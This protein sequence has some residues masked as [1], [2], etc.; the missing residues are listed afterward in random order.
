MLYSAGF[1]DHV[2]LE[3]IQ[4][5]ADSLKIVSGYATHTMA[6]WHI[7]E[8]ANQ[9]RKPISISLIC[10]MCKYDGISIDV[11]TG[12]Q[13]IIKGNGKPMGEGNNLV[14]SDL[15]CQY[16]YEGLP[17]HSKIYVWE[18]NGSPICAYTGSA[19]YTQSAFFDNRREL[20][21]E[22][23]PNKALQYYETI[24]RDSIYCNYSEIEEHITITQKHPILNA[25]SETKVAVQGENFQNVSLSLLTRSG[26][27][28]FGSGINW[29]HRRNGMK[30]EPNQAYIS[31]PVKVARSGFFPLGKRHFSVIT[32]DHKQLILRVEQQNDKAIT[33]PLN[34]SLLGEYLRGRIGVANGAFVTKQDLLN[35]KT[36]ITFY[37]LDDEQFYMDFSK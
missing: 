30:R 21:Q 18:K 29:G 32:D 37:K 1:R 19:N 15:T 31:L 17:V 9:F 27:V 5:G 23:D 4:Q 8:I 26:D 11:H 2:L 20:L 12:F 16:V 14:Q 36:D 13:D 33:T 7:K 24:E 22:C 34:N 35:Y 25:E 3:P 6:S 10:G 28:G